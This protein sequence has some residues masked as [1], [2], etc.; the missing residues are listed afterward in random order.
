MPG[1]PL[2]TDAIVL[3]RKPPADRFQQF[4]VL[5]GTQGPLLCLRRLATKSAAASD[6]LD[7]FDEADLF[8]D[9]SNEGRTWFIKEARVLVHHDA[10]GRSYDALRLASVFAGVIARNPVSEEG[11]AG[12]YVL[13]R[14]A[15]AAF[16]TSARP[17]IVYL[18]ALYCFARDEGYPVKQEWWQGLPAADRAVAAGL[19]NQPLAAQT[20]TAPDVARLTRRL[21]DYLRAF[22]EILLD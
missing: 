22:T 10:I 2:H 14:Q 11:R 17:D 13:L 16:G 1:R 7:L 19:F 4:T 20:A 5:S 6:A 3:L 8:L 15:L 9:S 12:V 18:K 21:E